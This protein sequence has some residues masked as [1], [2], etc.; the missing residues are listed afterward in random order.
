MTAV[1][2]W[3]AQALTGNIVGEVTLAGSSS[4]SSRFGGG[5]FRAGISVG[6]L[7]TR[8]R[9]KI[10]WAAVSRV[11]SW[12]T[13]GRYTLVLTRGT[14]CLGEWLIMR[15]TETTTDGILQVEGMEW[16]GY[17]A[18]R[19]LNDN[20]IYTGV[21]QITIA[22]T[23]LQ[24]AFVSYQPTMQITIPTA[25]SGVA[26][27]MDYKSHSAYYGDLLDEIS[28]PDDGF[29]WRVTQ[30]LTWSGGAP[31]KVTRT[32]EFGYPAISRAT[33]IV[34]DHD[35]PSARSGNCTAFDQ[36]YDF[37]RAAQ[38]VYGI[39]AGEGG[40]QKWVGLSD[41][42]L[43][44]QGYLIT[45]KNVSFPGVKDIPTLTALTRGAL[46]AAQILRD[47]AQATLLVEK[48]PAWPRVGDQVGIDVEPTYTLPTGREGTAR[49]GDVSFSL[50]GSHTATVTVQA[51]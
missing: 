3:V 42:T 12:C 29:D 49:L 50:T 5:T 43:T 13:G 32:I 48:I 10:D 26:R 33:Q 47:P 21:D 14:T 6:H 45:T 51:I 36:G 11:V 15:H 34:I 46:A 23:L 22:R 9:T 25:T 16:D 8:D 39:G 17:P 35:G 41:P 37:R 38:S 7:L 40:K 1:R 4:W 18:L 30:T 19:S 20:Y 44:N 28:E 24:A 27:T 31:T 2:A